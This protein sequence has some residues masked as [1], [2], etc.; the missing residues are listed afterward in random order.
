[1]NTLTEHARHD[2]PLDLNPLAS[3]YLNEENG[4][5]VPFNN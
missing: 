5:V 1:M 2:E 4:R 3:E